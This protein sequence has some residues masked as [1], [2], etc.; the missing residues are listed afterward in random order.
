M[1][2]L[3]KPVQMK[4][5]LGFGISLC[6]SSSSLHNSGDFRNDTTSE[7]WRK[8]SN[9]KVNSAFHI[10]DNIVCMK[11]PQNK[12]KNPPVILTLPAISFFARHQLC[13]FLS[14]VSKN[15]EIVVTH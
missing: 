9:K 10:N 8:N 7:I 2:F 4:R 15:E 14:A 5:K 13:F 6:I 11:V 3:Q 12:Q 1:N